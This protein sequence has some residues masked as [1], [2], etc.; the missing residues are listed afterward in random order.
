MYGTRDDELVTRWVQLGVFSPINRLYSSKTSF[1]SKHPWDY[2][3]EH[4]AVMK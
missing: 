4:G 1:L 2:P 3:A